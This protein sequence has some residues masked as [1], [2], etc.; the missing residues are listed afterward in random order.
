MTAQRK[1][2]A[3]YLA[4]AGLAVALALGAL[5]ALPGSQLQSIVA[6][7]TPTASGSGTQQEAEPDPGPVPEILAATPSANPNAPTAIVLDLSDATIGRYGTRTKVKF[8]VV[9][10]GARLRFTWQRQAPSGGAWKA[11]KGATSSKYTARA[12]TWRN[13]TR[14]RVVVKGADRTVTS[15]AAKL[16]VLFPTRTPAADAQTA[17]GLTG[18]TQGVDLSAYQHT[19][20]A[21][22][23]LSA[24]ASWAG[25]GGFTL[26]RNGSGA[27][28][29]KQVYTSVC[30][31]KSHRTG[32][33]PVTEDCAYA[34]F[35]D[36]AQARGLKLGHY[37]FNGWITSIDTTSKNLFSG[38]Y[39]PED[40]AG[41]FVAWLIRDG[42]YTRASTDPLVLDIEAGRA[43][44]KTYKGKKY[45]RKLRAW[46]PTEATAWLTEVRDLLTSKGYQANLYVYMSANVA[47]KQVLGAYKWA[48]VA[49]IARLWVASWGTNNG[50][51]PD[52][53][54]K[55]GPWAGTGGW[56]IWQYTSNA[57]IPGDGVGAID[58][59]IA[60]A[61]AWTP[62]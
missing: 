42:N 29:K 33:K 32:S 11:I 16:T 37:W 58:G 17:F 14:F 41:A 52:T 34:R 38:D 1:R 54:P 62:R 15:R 44:T 27:R 12:T 61:D 22:V 4:I 18:L 59:D 55:V 26:L 57:S 47:D 31:N 56:S 28:P 51:I 49:G 53:L 9:A 36:A 40:S 35:A 8:V 45:T 6:G 7:A 10:D 48:G 50:R 24:V 43:W 13:G 60:T 21:T 46:N 25:T 39:T 20:S 2:P 3:M 30:T 5:F 19:P 23:K